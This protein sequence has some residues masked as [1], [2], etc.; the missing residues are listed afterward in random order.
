MGDF[1]NRI[2]L[3]FVCATLVGIGAQAIADDSPSD[4]PIKTHHQ[5]MKHCMAEQKAK[6]KGASKED[7]KQ[8]CDNEIRTYRSHPS[9]TSPSEAPPTTGAG[10]LP[11]TQ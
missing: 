1:M 2:L 3:P 6:N 4:Q 10:P 7:M 11:P 5:L 8:K 9:V